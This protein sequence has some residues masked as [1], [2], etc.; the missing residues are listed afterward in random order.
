[1]STPGRGSKT[2]IALVESHPDWNARVVY[3]DTD[4]LFV[5]LPGRDVAGAT[6]VGAAIAAAVTA[7]NPAP[8]ELKLEKVYDPCI[9]MTKKRYAGLAYTAPGAAPTFDAKGIETVR[10]DTCPAVAKVL[11][12]L[13]KQVAYFKLLGSYPM[14]RLQPEHS[15]AMTQGDA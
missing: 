6:A 3:G 13:Q 14:D 7:A 10:R 5:S 15:P 12:I 4:S 8:V 9:L 1:M 11:A 2:A